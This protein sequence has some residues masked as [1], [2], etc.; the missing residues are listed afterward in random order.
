VVGEGGHF[1]C[2]QFVFAHKQSEQTDP[3]WNQGR[4]RGDLPNCQRNQCPRRRQARG[5]GLL[6]NRQAN[7]L[8]QGC[9][10][11]DWYRA[12]WEI[13][14]F[15]LVPKEGCRVVRLQLSDKD[16]LKGALAICM[17]IAWR[18]NRLMRLGHMMLD[19]DAGLLFDLTSGAPPSFSTKSQC[20]K[21]CLG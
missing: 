20:P 18:I 1:A 7:S 14:L 16:R 17:V 5:M 4:N 3:G 12:R 8:E 15:F 21:P 19:L 13:E 10:L 6:T 9:E 2:G 11:I